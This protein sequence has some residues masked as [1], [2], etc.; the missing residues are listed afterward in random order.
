MGQGTLTTDPGSRGYRVAW[1]TG[2]LI[3]GPPE[4]GIVWSPQCH[5]PVPPL[6]LHIACINV[7]FFGKLIPATPQ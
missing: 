6:S 2:R 7:G 5:A 4:H 1:Q 3:H